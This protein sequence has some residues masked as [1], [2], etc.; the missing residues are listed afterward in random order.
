MYTFLELV[1]DDN[2]DESTVELVVD[3]DGILILNLHIQTNAN[4][5]KNHSHIHASTRHQD[6]ATSLKQNMSTVSA[7]SLPECARN[8][9][10]VSMARK[11]GKIRVEGVDWVGWGWMTLALSRT[12]VSKSRLE[13][14]ALTLLL[15]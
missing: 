10:K 2:D 3:I 5:T 13:I 9:C 11:K 6:P 7:V 4:F 15:P 12:M 8:L 1:T 14:V